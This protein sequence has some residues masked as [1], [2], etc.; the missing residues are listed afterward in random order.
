MIC[1]SLWSG[2]G[3]YFGHRNRLPHSA[4]SVCRPVK[5]GWLFFANSTS[6]FSACLN[7]TSVPEC[8]RDQL[9]PNMTWRKC[10]TKPVT[11]S[12]L[13]WI[14]KK[15]SFYFVSKIVSTEEFRWVSF[16]TNTV[17]TWTALPWWRHQLKTFSSPLALCDGNPPV[18]GG[19]PLQRPVTQSFDLFLA[20][21]KQ[22]RRRWFQTP[23][24]S[25]WRH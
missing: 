18:T 21:I 1:T 23:S 19:F 22:S 2:F 12:G 24:G 4:V 9:R 3:V 8:P 16:I 20:R 14:S 10:K 11:P 7:H 15:C 13:G 5:S 6:P 17:E 25:S